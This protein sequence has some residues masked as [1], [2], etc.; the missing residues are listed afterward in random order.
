M[1]KTLFLEYLSPYNSH[2]LG[3]CSEKFGI[4]IFLCYQGIKYRNILQNDTRYISGSFIFLIKKN[5][6]IMEKTRFFLIFIS[7]IAIL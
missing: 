6:E 4:L 1:A 3:H 2:F 5:N 7:F